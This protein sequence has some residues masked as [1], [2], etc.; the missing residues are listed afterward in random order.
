MAKKLTKE[1]V[2]ML[3]GYT[4][5]VVD[6]QYYYAVS[7]AFEDKR[8]GDARTSHREKPRSMA[9]LMVVKRPT[10]SERSR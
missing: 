4:L 6:G 3:K 8:T 5:K 7:I 2:F 9:R 10:S 1:R